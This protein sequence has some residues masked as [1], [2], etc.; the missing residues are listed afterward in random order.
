MQSIK[1]F[2]KD[3]VQ[4]KHTKLTA[5]GFDGTHTLGIDTSSLLSE[6]GSAE[7]AQRARDILLVACTAQGSFTALNM[8]WSIRSNIWNPGQRNP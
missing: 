1:L 5:V 3:V 2:N 4:I 8:P 6:V 7:L